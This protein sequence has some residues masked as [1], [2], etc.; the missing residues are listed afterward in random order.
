M[1]RMIFHCPVKNE[2]NPDA[3]QLRPLKMIEA[4]RQIGYDVAVVYGDGAERKKS[5]AAI[6]RSIRGGVKYDFL[7]SESST[8]PTL[9]TE[10]HHLPSYPFLDFSFLSFCRR[11]GIRVGLFYRDIYWRF[12]FGNDSWKMK[13][14]KPF[15]IYDL[16]MYRRLVDVLFLPSKEMLGYIPLCFPGRV[17]E[18]PPGAGKMS[19]TKTGMP[20][21]GLNLLYIGGLVP[22]YDLRMLVKAVSEIPEITFTLCC[23]K[24]EWMRVGHFYD[25]LLSDNIRVVHKSG[26][27]LDALYREADLFCIYVKAHEYWKF[28]VP[29]K[30]FESI[31]HGCPV[32]ASEGTWT[33]DFVSREGIGP[34]CRYDADEL[35]RLLKELAGNR[36]KLAEYR[37]R[38]TDIAPEHTWQMR[39][40]KVA[41]LLL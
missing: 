20:G 18:L 34:V 16:I 28:A 22:H 6:K 37:K 12:S 21:Q 14:L 19:F 40:R 8:L 35:V 15:Y 10:K 39:C 1:R 11:H 5:I 25:G 31:G 26:D 23:R 2:G 3:S 36:G 30:L 4:F 9:C 33:A 17:E 27:E 38:V 32:L 29:F 13:C 41:H 24:K 7:Y